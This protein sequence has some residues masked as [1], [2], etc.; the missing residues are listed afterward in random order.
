MNLI[1]STF[2]KLKGQTLIEL[3]LVMGLAA[4][5][6]PALLTGFVASRNG[7]PQ[8][9]QRLQA[10][11]VLKET[12]AAL[13]NIRNTN[14]EALASNGTFHT[15]IS[16][17][18]W[19]LAANSLTNSNGIKQEIVI[20]D[21]YRDP[22]SGEIVI[23]GGVVDPS[24]KKIDINI[25]W[26]KP[27]VSNINSTMFLTRTK[28]TTFTQTT[29][30][31]FNQGVPVRTAVSAT[32]GSG[33][34]GHIALTTSGD[35]GEGEVGGSSADWCEPN[36]SITARDLPKN[37]VA[38]AVSAIPGSVFVGTGENA[39]GVSFANV[40]ITDTDPP[41]SSLL[42]TFNGYKTN[43]VFGEENYAYLATDTNSKEIVIVNLAASPHSE[44]GY[45]N[46]PG[47]GDGNSVFVTGNI[48]YMTDGNRLYTF[49]LSAKSGS[50]P[51]LGS[52]VL[53]GTGN[54][55]YVVG[56]YVYV[57]ID[58]TSNQLEIIQVSNN[59]ATLLRV[60]SLSLPGQRA[61]DVIV[62][63]LGTR[64]YMVTSTS[65]TQREMFVIDINSK[66]S[67]TVMGSYE[68]NGMNPSAVTV[69]SA[70]NRAIIV[71]QGGEE[72]QVIDISTET[73]PTRCGGLNINTGVNGVSSV[74]EDDGDAYS[75][76]ITGDSSSELKIIE[77]GQGGTVVST[78][79]C[80]PQDAIINSLTLPR[81]GNVVAAQQG[82]A[83]VGSGN[84]TSGVEFVDIALTNPPPPTNPTSSIIST[85]TG[86]HQ[87]NAVY[88]DGSY[89]YLAV[90]GSSSQVLILNIAS[91]PFSQVGTINLPSGTNANGIFVTNNIAY[92]TS[93]DKLYTFDVTTKSGA[94][95]TA[96]AQIDMFRQVGEN[97]TAKQV[98]VVGSKA[99]VGVAN[100]VYG[101][102]VFAV[103]SGGI[104]LEN[105]GVSDLPF[106]QSATGLSVNSTGTRSYVSFNNGSGA[107]QRGFF[108][109]DT[110]AGDPPDWWSVPNYYPII[111]TY[112]SGSTDPTGIALA[113]STSNRALLTGTG[114]T[115][116]YHAVDISVEA[117]PILCGGMTIAQ[118]I[119]GI[120]SIQ[121]S[122]DRGFAYIITDEAANQFKIIQGGSGGGNY[123]EDGTFESSI[124]TATNSAAFNRFVATVNSPTQTTLRMQVAAFPK[125][126]S[127]CSGAPYTYVGPDGSATS[128]F[129]PSGSTIASKIPFGAYSPSYE[130]PAECFRYKTYFTTWDT[131]ETPTFNDITVNYSP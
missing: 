98:S 102:Q 124:F 58:S 92:V 47:N 9:E 17:A 95:N 86:S 118:G 48:G 12:E 6:L 23:T 128:F 43:D 120:A 97:P 1:F 107:V 123:I 37:G 106:S 32:G 96:L 119:K 21:V 40:N 65:T 90:N 64:A 53:D 72:Y 10:I 88:S 44:V 80:S 121:D 2:R 73:S 34:D 68:A 13:K 108:V 45:F 85:S 126:N 84:G 81:P 41:N 100:T 5:I 51:Q 35:E 50:R 57:A 122:F 7:K 28:N 63:E 99:F 25:S 129:N 52:V 55:I 59:G 115:Y 112:N 19:S 79:W 82:E 22:I 83:F 56:S 91:A 94:H 29:L 76:I 105:V 103:G 127:V 42:G 117:D 15:E 125:V 67:P 131:A 109:V 87:T 75:Y 16:G 89:A 39:S 24:T 130:N 71:G 26:T 77:G 14:W 54:N 116:Q 38:N 69:M 60:G 104:L 74:F 8:Q 70:H 111:G 27:T 18:Q 11:S 46:A 93:S 101:L 31:D 4:I 61:Q 3:I 110:S 36:L 20:S 49:D 33:T 113:A 30:S 78:N 114:G 66:S 62:S